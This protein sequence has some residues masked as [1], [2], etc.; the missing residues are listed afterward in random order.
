MSWVWGKC[1][2]VRYL[3]SVVSKRH[4]LML[5]MFFSSKL[6]HG[7]IMNAALLHAE[8]KVC[9]AMEIS[10]HSHRSLR[11]PHNC[12][13]HPHRRRHGLHLRSAGLGLA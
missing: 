2:A 7:T 4:T 9:Q 8:G 6:E 3:D 1:V 12:R 13:T 10:R 11:T 5:K